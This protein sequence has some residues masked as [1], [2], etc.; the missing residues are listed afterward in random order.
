MKLFNELK[1]ILKTMNLTNRD[2]AI[3]G[4]GIGMFIISYL[5]SDGSLPAVYNM[6]T[7][8]T[9]GYYGNDRKKSL[10]AWLGLEMCY[11]LMSISEGNSFIDILN[12]TCGGIIVASM[13]FWLTIRGSNKTAEKLEELIHLK[14]VYNIIIFCTFITGL[15]AYAKMLSSYSNNF[16][17]ALWIISPLYIYISKLVYSE[18]A[19]VFRLFYLIAVGITTYQA[20]IVG[21]GVLNLIEYSLLL[22][23]L[24]LSVMINLKIRKLTKESADVNERKASEKEV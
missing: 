2:K 17:V 10:S 12:N 23:S 5:N 18:L 15:M 4:L 8:L 3:L 24:I 6:F 21:G 11:L 16:V 22:V 13:A 9:F 20:F 19:Y 7:V 1:I 14:P